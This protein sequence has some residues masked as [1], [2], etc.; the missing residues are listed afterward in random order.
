[1]EME[2]ICS[3]QENATQDSFL[4]GRKQ[5]MVCINIRMEITMKGN[6]EKI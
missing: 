2:F 3:L 1:M 6:G 5:E 4:K